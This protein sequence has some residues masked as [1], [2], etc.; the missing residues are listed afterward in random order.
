MPCAVRDRELSFS[1]SLVWELNQ[2]DSYDM[3]QDPRSVCP[4]SAGATGRTGPR[5]QGTPLVPCIS[6]VQLVLGRHRLPYLMR[7]RP[8]L[9]AAVVH[10]DRVYPMFVKE[11]SHRDSRWHR[12][13]SGLSQHDGDQGKEIS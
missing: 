11:G 2:T 8:Y 7:D 6:A 12:R 5:I 1:Q 10:T 13:K 4:L 9:A 3:I